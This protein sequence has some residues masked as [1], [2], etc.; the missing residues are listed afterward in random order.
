MQIVDRHFLLKCDINNLN[1]HYPGCRP[2]L[3]TLS[4]N[5]NIAMGHQ[6][7]ERTTDEQLIYQNLY[8]EFRNE[9][10]YA[11]RNA[12]ANFFRE[13]LTAMHKCSLKF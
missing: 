9:V 5:E 13:K 3:L 11:F 4:L 2:L 7:L 12:K 10:K 1:L 8:R 6:F